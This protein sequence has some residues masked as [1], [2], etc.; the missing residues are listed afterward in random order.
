MDRLEKMYYGI[1]R[2]L[3]NDFDEKEYLL[4]KKTDKEKLGQKRIEILD[5][6]YG[7]NQEKKSVQELA[8]MYHTTYEKMLSSLR[9]AKEF[10]MNLYT[11]RNKTIKIDPSLYRKYIEDPRFQFTEEARN[12]LKL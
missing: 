6:Y 9:D 3:E 10:A 7:I 4:V 2:I 1:Y 5:N 12:L 8:V 11:N